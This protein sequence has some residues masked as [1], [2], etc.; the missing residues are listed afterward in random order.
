MF[1]CR[2]CVAGVMGFVDDLQQAFPGQCQMKPDA[3]IA[4]PKREVIKTKKG[5]T[6]EQK[7]FA[8]RRVA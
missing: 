5:F 1:T 8:L 7:A 6:E 4:R 2:S 3:E